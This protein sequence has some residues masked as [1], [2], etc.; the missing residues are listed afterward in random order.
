[1]SRFTGVVEKV[2][3]GAGGYALVTDGGE[4]LLLNGDVPDELVG[5]KVV[6]RGSKAA[7]MGFLMT[8]DATL[9]VKRIE[10]A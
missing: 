4:R 2:D 7:A 10:A 9:T 6:V 3:L 8:G 1:M 5:R